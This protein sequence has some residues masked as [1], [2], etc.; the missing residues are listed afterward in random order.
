MNCFQRAWR[1]CVRKPVKSILLLLVVFIISLF[2]LSGM[3]SKN[4]SVAT[5]DKTRQA[6]GA[7]LLLEGN[8]ANRHQRIN[9]ISEKIGENT[10][11]SLD[12]VHQKKLESSSGISWQV[13]TD[14]FFETL[15][16]EDIDKIAAVNG[17]SDVNITTVT[18]AVNP[19]NFFRIED[20]DVDQSSDKLAVSLIGNQDMKLDSN[21]LSGNLFIKEGRM[22]GKYDLN[23]CVIS[24]EIA[25]K[26]KLK[27]GDQ[28]QFNDYHQR[29]SSTIYEAQIIGIYQVKQ[30]MTPY[31]SGDTYRSENVIFTDLRFPEKAEGSENDPLFE[32]AYFKVGDVDNYNSV[33]KAIKK[34][35]IDWE[36]Y[37][38]IDNN[39]NLDTMSKNFNDLQNLSQILIWAVVGAS[40][41]ILFLVFVFWMKNRVQEVG[42]LLALG[43]PKIGILS[44]ILVEAIMI[45]LIAVSI[46]FVAAPG[47]SKITTTYLVAQQVQ[48]SEEDKVLNRGK[49]ATD[50]PQREAEVTGVDVEI[51]L[52]ML[53]QDGMGVISLITFTV[54]TAGTTILRRNPK[55]ILSEMS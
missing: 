25:E 22:V 40:V 5:Q 49:I 26:N 52:K 16:L 7:G 14:N 24:E 11:G 46:S 23:V 55:D 28:L 1:S 39:G 34:A 41:V 27:V 9:R 51:S 17:I 4:A 30:K 18:T 19:V 21:V 12:G 36:R 35:D 2:L 44:Q 48:Q 8:E 54:A 31:M 33:K 42:I 6:I 43:T 3:A 20:V 13:W 37:D 50:Y 15:K 10:E 45:A 32:K 38:L 47:V 53:L 29:E